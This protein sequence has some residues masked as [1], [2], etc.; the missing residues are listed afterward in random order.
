MSAGGIRLVVFDVYQTLLWPRAGPQDSES[1]W[2][3]LCDAAGVEG[4][5]FRE[6]GDASAA[7]VRR[8]NDLARAAGVDCPEV[9]WR[10]VA[11]AVLPGLGRLHEEACEAFLHGHARLQ[12]TCVLYPGVRGVLARLRHAGMLL[13]MASN[14]QEYTRRELTAAALPLSWLEHDLQFLSGDHGYAKPSPRVFR[15]LSEAA[16]RRGIAPREILMVGDR[17][18][19]DI[20]PAREAGWQTWHLRDARHGWRELARMLPGKA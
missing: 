20:H 9:K 2:I 19:N 18:D 1:G 8:R 5:G 17:E 14:G 7:E 4:L 12:R 6:F 10:E 11:V 13:G 15:W 16:A 3:R